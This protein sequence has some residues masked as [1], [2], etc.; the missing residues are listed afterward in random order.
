MGLTGLII[1]AKLK[2]FKLK[3]SYIKISDNKKFDNFNDIYNFLKKNN[4]IYNQNN[5]FFKFGKNKF[6]ISRISSGNFTNSNY[7]FKS[8]NVGNIRSFRSGFLKISFFRKLLEKLLL[9]KEYTNNQN[10]IHINEA[11]F[12]SNSRL[13]YFN[14]MS[15][16]FMENQVIIP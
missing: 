11:F 12:P 6:I 15:K 16:K 4:H 8:L 7:N 3:S 10:L 14:L 13:I 2:V 1:K 5:L 9:I